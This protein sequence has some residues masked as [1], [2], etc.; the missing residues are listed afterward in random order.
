MAKP[1]SYRDL[2][3]H[4]GSTRGHTPHW[5]I[6]LRQ[7]LAR[8]FARQQPD[9]SA[10]KSTV[11]TLRADSSWEHL[12]KGEDR[13]TRRLFKTCE[14]DT[15]SV[16][17]I[18]DERFLLLGWQWPNQAGKRGCRADLV[19][20]NRTGGLVVFEAKG[21]V[22]TDSPLQ[23]MLE[24]LDYLVHLTLRQNF[25]QIEALYKQL[26]TEST[27]DLPF[28][29]KHFSGKKPS[30]LAPHEV[31]VLAPSAYYER[32]TRSGKT[33]GRGHGWHEFAGSATADSVTLR[34]R[35]AKTDF[36]ETSATW[37]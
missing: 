18:G 14:D 6:V 21:P 30:L 25:A 13:A 33:A 31:I 35:Y 16:F 3:A 2:F 36:K 22:N 9:L 7:L 26:A 5:P 20:L 34:F 19:G 10:Y 24:G 15:Q 28:P 4:L 1:S 27:S 17:T 29:P 37:V 32:Y 23:A 8:D 11:A 12:E